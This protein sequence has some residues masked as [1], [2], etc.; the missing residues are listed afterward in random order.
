MSY[1]IIGD[2]HG[3]FDEVQELIALGNSLVPNSEPIFVGDLLDRGNQCE[4]M[5][6]WLISTH[7]KSVMGN[8]DW[9]LLRWLKGEA[10]VVEGYPG[11]DKTLDVLERCP[12]LKAPLA[13]YLETLPMSHTLILPGTP[14]LHIVHAAAYPKDV[15]RV[16][17]KSARSRMLY[18]IT[19]GE[20]GPDGYPV[21]LEFAD[22]WA[23]EES[24][25]VHGHVVVENAEWRG[26]KRNVLDLDTGCAY[27]KKLSGLLYPML[28]VISVPSK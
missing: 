6:R 7:P 10:V 4:E 16:G 17:S 12:E 27:G 28:E 3:C 14:T 20:I 1:L 24:L 19:T 22:S 21:R 23:K 5:I 15:G 8:H 13:A 26:L 11:I 25:L 9:K 2:A 18:G